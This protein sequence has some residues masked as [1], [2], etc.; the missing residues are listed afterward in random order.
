M[1]VFPHLCGATWFLGR[2]ILRIDITA[3]GL[4]ALSVHLGGRSLKLWLISLSRLPRLGQ[5][6]PA[7]YQFSSPRGLIVYS[8]FKQ[9]LKF[10]GS[11]RC[12]TR[13]DPSEPFVTSSRCA[14]HFA[15]PAWWHFVTL[16]SNGGLSWWQMIHSN[17]LC[18]HTRRIIR[19]GKINVQPIQ[20]PCELVQSIVDSS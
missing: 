8:P 7:C 17:D 4:D 5:M 15:V 1:W 12:R 9:K 11:Q 20:M 18:C 10:S 2:D 14:H 3:V 16:L 6:L 13:S 19:A